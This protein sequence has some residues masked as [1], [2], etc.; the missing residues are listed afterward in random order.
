MGALTSKLYAYKARPWEVSSKET[1]SIK[2]PFFQLIK[3]EMRDRNILRILPVIGTE[4]WIDDNT[5]FFVSTKPMKST[6][7]KYSLS[8]EY[9][10]DG[11]TI[12]S[13]TV[14][15]EK[16]TLF[17]AVTTLTQQITTRKN[18]TVIIDDL[19][20]AQTIAS[21]RNLDYLKQ[22]I[23][24]TYVGVTHRAAH[25][26]SYTDFN[27]IETDNVIFA[28][29]IKPLKQLFET[30]LINYRQLSLNNLSISDFSFNEFLYVLEGYIPFSSAPYFIITDSLAKFIPASFK[31]FIIDCTN[32]AY[33]WAIS[34]KPSFF[35]PASNY[36]S[37]DA[38]LLISDN[39]FNNASFFT[40]SH[41]FKPKNFALFIASAPHFFTQN[42]YV[43]IFGKPIF[44]T[45]ITS[46][47]LSIK[48]FFGLL[49]IYTKDSLH[50]I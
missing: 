20:D 44:S 26:N 35:G 34:Q 40:F 42:T 24:I 29:E 1:V 6:L 15:H 11:F 22:F 38:N 39:N 3:V 27:F 16:I 23:N 14:Y 37:L 5:R 47:A 9:L 30:K 33:S 8:T 49:S 50:K 17:E 21:I 4:E 13:T 2:D 46:S 43:D 32:Q 28:K 12:M 41:E 31:R 25:I 7:A 10:I 48:H 36:L 18:L 19:C 45:K